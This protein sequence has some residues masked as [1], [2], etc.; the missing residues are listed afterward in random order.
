M[1]AEIIDSSPFKG[2]GCASNVC[3]WRVGGGW[4][5]IERDGPE[6]A[7]VFPHPHPIPP[8]EGE[9]AAFHAIA[10]QLKLGS[11]EPLDYMLY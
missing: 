10:L 11:L 3:D 1:N 7:V 2:E 8:L 9:G 5:Y 4:G 6:K